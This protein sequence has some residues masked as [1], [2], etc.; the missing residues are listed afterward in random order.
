M[1]RRKK[2][3]AVQLPLPMVPDPLV[4]LPKTPSVLDL[5]RAHAATEAAIARIEA[6]ARA[7]YL[8]MLVEGVRSVALGQLQ[9]ASDQVW[10]HL[11]IERMHQGNPSALGVAFRNAAKLGYIRPQGERKDSE[12]PT[13]HRRPLRIWESRIYRGHAHG[14]A[15]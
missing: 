5:G 3:R 4:A 15:A 1:T 13:T 2:P 9:L 7:A 14:D 10:E 11:G 8:D 6:S 12:R